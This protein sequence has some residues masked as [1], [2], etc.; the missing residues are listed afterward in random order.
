MSVHFLLRGTEYTTRRIL[1]IITY[2]Y[3]IEPHSLINRIFIIYDLAP[4]VLNNEHKKRNQT[5]TYKN[6][7]SQEKSKDLFYQGKVGAASMD[8]TMVSHRGA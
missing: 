4:C 5:I 6:N 1:Y 8:V 3:I 2:F 7:F